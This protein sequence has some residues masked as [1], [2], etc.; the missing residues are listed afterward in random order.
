VKKSVRKL[1]DDP[2]RF[3]FLD[4]MI[5]PRT[6]SR[7]LFRITENKHRDLIQS[8]LIIF[9]LLGSFIS[10]FPKTTALAASEMN[11]VFEM[12]NGSSRIGSDDF[13]NQQDGCSNDYEPDDNYSEAQP[14]ATNGILQ[15]HVNTPPTDED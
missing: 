11:P 4:A 5:I 6:P 8:M 14:I 12:R 7:F 15:A 9:L 10:T 2:S 1:A 13:L 3:Y